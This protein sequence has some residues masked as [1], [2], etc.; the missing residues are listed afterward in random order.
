MVRLVVAHMITLVAAKMVWLVVPLV[1]WLIL[2]QMVWFGLSNTTFRHP[3]DTLVTGIGS[4]GWLVVAHMV[5]LVVAYMVWLV[6]AHIGLGAVS[7]RHAGL[8]RA[9]QY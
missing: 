3:F 4:H 7:G 9:A 6:V 1:V 5:W 2:A 8:G